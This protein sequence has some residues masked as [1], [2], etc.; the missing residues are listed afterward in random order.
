MFTLWYLVFNNP[1]QTLK[2]GE[3]WMSYTLPDHSSVI[4][5]RQSELVYDQDYNQANRKVKLNGS[6]HFEVQAQAEKPF[7]V[8]ANQ[9]T[10]TVLGTA[11]YIHYDKSTQTTQV[12]VDHGKVAVKSPTGESVILLA[13]QSCTFKAESS[14]IETQNRI[15]PNLLSWKTQSLVFTQTPLNEVITD[16][17]RTYGCQIVLKDGE[18]ASIPLT[19]NYQK[20]PLSSVLRLISESLNLRFRQEGQQIVVEK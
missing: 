7:I 11:F 10:V 16:I 12:S 20:L 17:N 15:S 13:H 9:V 1:E 3:H 18:I 14:K 2:S 6:A 5:N 8:E 19:A 4:L